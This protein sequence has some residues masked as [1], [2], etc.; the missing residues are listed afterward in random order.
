MNVCVFLSFI[1]HTIL[2]VLFFSCLPFF[3]SYS[4]LF[5]LHWLFFFVSLLFWIKEMGG[6]LE[7][8]VLV[9]LFA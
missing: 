8:N 7:F 4:S 2:N 3:R 9:W 5:V 1:Q 6:S